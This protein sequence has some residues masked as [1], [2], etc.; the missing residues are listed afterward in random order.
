MARDEKHAGD[1]NKPWWLD[2]QHPGRISLPINVVERG[3]WYRKQMRYAR[4]RSEILDT[5]VLVLAAGVPFAVAVHA[6]GW[7]TALL[8]ALAAVGTGTRQIYGWQKNWKSFASASGQ[9]EREI[10]RFGYGMGDYQDAATAAERLAD[11]VEDITAAETGAWAQRTDEAY[12][13]RNSP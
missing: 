7:A 2:I 3:F 4:L 6:P 8:G 12:N 5:C 9:I 11:R 10:V 13:S 1:G